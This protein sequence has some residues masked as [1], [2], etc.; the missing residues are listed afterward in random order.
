MNLRLDWCSQEA[1]KFAVTRW[2][3]SKSLP[4]PPHVRVGVWE[5]GKFIGVVLFS[6]GANNNLLKPY[7]LKVTEGC[8]LARV[9]LSK[10]ETPVTRIISIAINMLRSVNSG[11]KLVVSFSDPKHGHHGGIYQGGNWLYLGQSSDTTEFLAP[12][13]KIWHGRMV[14]ADGTSRVYGKRRKVWRTDQCQKITMPGKHRYLMPLDADMKAHVSHMAKPYPKRAKQAMAVPTVQRQGST[15]PHAPVNEGMKDARLDPAK[16]S[17][18][19]CEVVEASGKKQGRKA[20]K[21][22]A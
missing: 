16:N 20:A 12:D 1:A 18:G 21:A 10:H 8:E 22:A 19:C 15:D 17:V 13:G 14:S 3:Y 9:A 11:L 7:G 2:H 4:P 6:R 5:N